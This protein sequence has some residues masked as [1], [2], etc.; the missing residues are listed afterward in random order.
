MRQA[1]GQTSTNADSSAHIERQR[2]KKTEGQ[3]EPNPY[4]ALIT[5]P[6]IKVHL[7]KKIKF[8]YTRARF[9]CRPLY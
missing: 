7:K 8:G 5:P 9:Y 1:D 2:D 6:V 4:L 3:N